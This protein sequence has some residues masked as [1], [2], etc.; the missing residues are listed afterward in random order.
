MTAENI[1]DAA[2][3]AVVTVIP[4][5]NFFF[6]KFTSGKF[7]AEPQ[8]MGLSMDLTSRVLSNSHAVSPQK[9]KFPL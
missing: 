3:S 6:N 5:G 1:P 9:I 8:D 7:G 2:S 4:N